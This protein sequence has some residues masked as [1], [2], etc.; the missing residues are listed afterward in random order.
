MGC[1][2]D[3]ECFGPRNMLVGMRNKEIAHAEGQNRT[4]AFVCLGEIACK[5]SQQLLHAI[6]KVPLDAT[7]NSTR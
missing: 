5:S 4:N 3:Q 2:R 7:F 6:R 1:Q